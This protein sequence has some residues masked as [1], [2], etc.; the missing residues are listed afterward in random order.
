[1]KARDQEVREAVLQ[2]RGRCL[3]CLDEIQRELQAQLSRKLLVE[4][5]R[6]VIQVKVKL[7]GAIIAKARRAIVAG[8]RPKGAPPPP[9]TEEA[10]P[11]PDTVPS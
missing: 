2:E 7:A 1:M 10:P 6:H 5:E 9:P 8:A 4:S 3:W 11:D